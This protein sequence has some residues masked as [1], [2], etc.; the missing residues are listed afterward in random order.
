MLEGRCPKCDTRYYGWALAVASQQACTKCGHK[1]DI[2]ESETGRLIATGN[3]IFE[4]DKYIVE[5]SSSAEKLL[6]G[7]EQTIKSS[8]LDEP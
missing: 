1:L 4:A 6:E 2:Y 5:A 8:E 7:S 3:S